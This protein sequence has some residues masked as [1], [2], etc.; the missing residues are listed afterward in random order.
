MP[1]TSDVQGWTPEK[2]AMAYNLEKQHGLPEGTLRG[3]SW[4]ESNFGRLREHS[5]T[6]QG[7][8]QLGKPIRQQ[9]GVPEAQSRNWQ[10][11]MKG[12]AAYAAQNMHDL[13]SRIGR[14]PTRDELYLAHQ[15]GEGAAGNF[16]NHPNTPIG[17]LTKAVNI[18]SN[19]GNPAAPARDFVDKFTKQ[20]EA[21]TKLG[22]N[23]LWN[24]PQAKPGMGD[25]QMLAGMPGGDKSSSDLSTM[26]AQA[27]TPKPPMQ[28]AQAASPLPPQALSNER[29]SALNSVSPHGD[30]SFRDMARN[31]ASVGAPN[32]MAMMEN[33]VA[34]PTQH[35]EAP[36]LHEPGMQHAQMMPGEG[37]SID[38]TSSMSGGPMVSPMSAQMPGMG[39]GL[40]DLFSNAVPQTDMMAGDLGG[41]F[42]GMN[43]GGFDLGGLFG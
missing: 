22:Q 37:M 11:S 18:R 3:M 27:A 2:E 17:R 10:E 39:G 12:G 36:V 9:Y 42:G 38:P 25:Q 4:V 33:P 20:F 30:N 19:H 34:P 41:S 28:M 5:N 24:G 13:Q 21:G 8:Y 6:Y 35:A 15:Q 40:G 43:F 29:Y 14:Q 23:E 7:E 16:I 32:R 1:L 31:S 26:L